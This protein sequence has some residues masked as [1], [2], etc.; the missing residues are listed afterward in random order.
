[1]KIF[2][3]GEGHLPVYQDQY[4]NSGEQKNS[5]VLKGEGTVP[6]IPACNFTPFPTEER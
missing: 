4:Y 6:D 1:M 3:V 5:E 2:Y